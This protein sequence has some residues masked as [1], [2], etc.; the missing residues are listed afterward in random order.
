MSLKLK[1]FSYSF[2]FV[3]CLLSFFNSQIVAQSTAKRPLTMQDFDSWRSLQGSTISR[4]G[5]FVA[6]VMQPQDGDGDLYVKA[7]AT[8]GEWRSPRGYRPPAPP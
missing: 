1:R 8:G 7:T 3:L 5:K 2:V 4:D 6:Y